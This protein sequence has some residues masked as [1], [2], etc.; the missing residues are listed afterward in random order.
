MNARFDH[1]VIGAPTLASGVAW[2]EQKLGIHMPPGGAHP[3]MGTHNHVMRLGP[4]SFCE[5]IAI[6]PAA[7]PPGRPRWFGLD[8]GPPGPRLL[9]WL[10]AVPDLVAAIAACPIDTGRAQPMTRGTLS[11]RLTVPDDGALIEAG[12]M[13]G[14]IEW[15]DPHPAVA[16]ADLGCTLV[17][18]DLG[19]PEPTRLRAALSAIGMNDFRIVVSAAREP[20]LAATIQTP[21]GLRHL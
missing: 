7:S 20:T 2:V 6:D 9:T 14:L 11:W 1:L 19:H 5:V 3:R 21:A 18:L 13:P 10:M 8:H 12:T 4:T 17:R 15:P 16:M